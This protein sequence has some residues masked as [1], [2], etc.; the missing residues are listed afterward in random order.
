MIKKIKLL[1]LVSINTFLKYFASNT[2]I[3]LFFLKDFFFSKN[4]INNPEDRNKNVF[5]LKFNKFKNNLF[6][7]KEKTK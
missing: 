7:R 3:I 2:L 1:I 5:L 6:V 4:L